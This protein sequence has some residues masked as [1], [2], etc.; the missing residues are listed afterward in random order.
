VAESLFGLG[1]GEVSELLRQGEDYWI[2][3]MVVK[4]AAA[5]PSF[6]EARAQVERDL[7]GEDARE[8]AV[9]EARQRLEELRRGEKPE[10]LAARLKGEARETAFFTQREFVAEAGLKGEQFAEAFALEAGSFGGPVAAPDGRIILYRVA[11]KVPA[12]REAF[13]A[14]KTTV[15]ERLRDAKKDRLFEAWLE[16]LR[17]VR[18][19]KINTQLV[20]NL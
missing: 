11:A 20:G 3:K 12:T 15:R 1:E 18:S 17:R 16:D 8:R 4:R 10:Q 5:A 9:G 14:E 2:Y 19:V 7:R 6:E 13:A